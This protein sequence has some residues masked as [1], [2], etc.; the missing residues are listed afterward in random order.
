MFG[1]F[2]DCAGQERPSESRCVCLSE[3]TLSQTVSLISILSYSCTLVIILSHF[4]TPHQLYLLSLSTAAFLFDHQSALLSLTSSSI[5]V[6]PIRF[7][8]VC[9]YVRLSVCLSV[10]TTRLEKYKD[11][12]A[13]HFDVK[14]QQPSRKPRRFVG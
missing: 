1:S 13:M 3:L 7:L 9:R 6:P 11:N 4:L 5:S 12:H 10:S 2:R 8:Y 14:W